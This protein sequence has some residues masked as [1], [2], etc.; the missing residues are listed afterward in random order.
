MPSIGKG[1]ANYLNDK[2]NNTDNDRWERH[3]GVYH[4]SDGKK[5]P[6]KVYYDFHYDGSDHDLETCA[7][8]ER[9]NLTEDFAE[10]VL[11]NEY[12]EEHVKNPIDVAHKIDD[13]LVVGQ[14]DPVIVENGQIIKGFEVKSKEGYN[15]KYILDEPSKTHVM[16]A[17]GYMKALGLNEWEIWYI[18]FPDF[19]D[20]VHTIEFDEDIWSEMRE[21]Y[22]LIHESLKKDELPPEDPIASW[23]CKEKYCP[24]WDRCQE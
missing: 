8:F 11:K 9:G 2:V 7:K 24:W 5:C 23:E 17:H 16:Q 22:R 19:H 10:E 13:F 20:R 4:V 21:R 14:T 6:R 3:E 15:F 18:K 1:I 12:G